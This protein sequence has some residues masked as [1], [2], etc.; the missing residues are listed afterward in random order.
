MALIGLLA[1][2]EYRY[3]IN[4]FPGN[5]SQVNWEINFA[6]GYIDRNHVKAIIEDADGNTVVPVLSWSGSYT[7]TV[8]PAV[9]FGSTLY[10][11][12]DTPKDNPLADFVDEAVINEQTLDRNARQAVFIAAESLD[13]S[14]EAL[15]EAATKADEAAASAV[16]AV[17]AAGTITEA[18]GAAD[19]ATAAANT[20][21]A[22]AV[23]A[24]GVATAAAAA[25]QAVVDGYGA[26]ITAAKDRANHTGTQPADTITETAGLKVMTGSERTKLS[27]IATGATANDTDA[28]L[29]SRANHTGTQAIST[30]SGLQG[31]LDAKA[32]LASPAFTGTPTGITKAHVG[33]GNVDNT[34]DVDKPVSTAQANAL[35]NRVSG[36]LVSQVGTFPTSQ[37]A[38]FVKD[39]GREGLFVWSSANLSAQVTADPAQGVYIPSSADTTGAAGAWVRKFSGPIFPSWF[40]AVGDGT[41]S[42]QTAFSRMATYANANPGTEI[43][44]GPKTY[45]IT[46]NITFNST[47]AMYGITAAISKILCVGTCGLL[48]D[49][50]TGSTIYAAKQMPLRRFGM[51]QSG[52]NTAQLLFV[53]YNASGDSRGTI[54]GGVLEDLDVCVENTSASFDTGILLRDIPN[55]RM[56]RV[57]VEGARTSPLP[58]IYGIRLITTTGNGSAVD[59]VFEDVSCFFVRTGAD[60]SGEVEGVNFVRPLMVGIRTGITW[61]AGTGAFQPSLW[62]TDGH[63]NA[64]GRCIR[65]VNIAELKIAGMEFYGQGVDGGTSDHAAVEAAFTPG[66]GARLNAQITGNMFQGDLNYSKPTRNEWAVVIH[67]LA[68]DVENATISDNLI[69]S[70]DTGIY[71]GVD[72]NGVTVSDT[73]QFASCGINV[74]DAAPNGANIVAQRSE[75][76]THWQRKLNDGTT[77]KGGS[78]VV[79]LDASGNG[80][81]P[82]SS[83]GAVFPNALLSGASVSNGDP[84]IASTAQFIVNHASS[85]TSQL[86]FSVRPNPGAIA[87]RAQYQATGR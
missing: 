53:G 70:Y 3:S 20:A 45:R 62:V 77:T 35:A 46:A 48:F 59:P 16:E 61:D 72:V 71:L 25:A 6:G 15:V 5:G 83:A 57:R 40:G 31:A 14:Y 30:V 10:V 73:N 22:G 44:L 55:I 9:H 37:A 80:T 4:T 12:R 23:A 32:P 21:A 19:E 17:E 36:L 18:L 29:K 43:S 34:A 67:G 42:D 66:L 8:T 85:T 26:D 1:N 54:P 76:G 49:G 51:V 41:T 75:S 52:V 58:C 86:A 13:A 87:V 84:G 69:Q 2:P 60:I 74:Y 65:A 33:L 11:Y 56:K 28:N 24:T 81:I 50:G 64:E 39:T 78:V 82:L 38:V 47:V 79:T 7:V 27:G 68:A 63:I